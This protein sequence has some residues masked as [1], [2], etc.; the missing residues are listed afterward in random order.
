AVG[1]LPLEFQAAEIVVAALQ[2]RSI[3]RPAQHRFKQ[4]N[5][6]VEDLVLK[7]LGAGGH[8]QPASVHQRGEQVSEGLTGSGSRLDDDVV[9]LC[10]RARHG[11]RHPHLR[12]PKLVIGKALL[13]KTAWLEELTHSEKL[14][15][16]GRSTIGPCVRG[17]YFQIAI[18]GDCT[19]PQ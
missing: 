5:V 10:E 6:F 13:E 12:G 19:N 17:I 8:E 3:D 11:F 4:R 1:E 7:C 2:V 18:S 14:Y 9:L 15:S 16:L